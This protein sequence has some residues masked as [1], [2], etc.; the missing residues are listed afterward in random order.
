MRCEFCGEDIEG[1]PFYKDGMCFCSLECADAMEGGETIPLG[2]DILD[3]P[4]DAEEVDED[5]VGREVEDNDDA[6]EEEV[7]GEDIYDDERGY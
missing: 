2:E 7:F 4:D 3:D 6:Y 1:H 5:A